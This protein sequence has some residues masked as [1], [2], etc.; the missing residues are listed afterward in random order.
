MSPSLVALRRRVSHLFDDTAPQTGPVRWFNTGLA[1]LIIVNVAA[2]ILESVAELRHAYE[3]IFWWIEQVATVVF[4]IEYLLRLWTAVDIAEGRYRD[5][6]AGRWRYSISFF[7][8]VDLVSILPAVLGMLGAAD[9]R[10]LRLLRLVRM[11]KLTRHSTVFTLLW[12]VV[13]EEA[14]SIGAILFIL[15][16]TLTMSGA[17][18]YMIEGDAQPELFSS[19]P[20]AMWWAIETL[21]TVGYGDVVPV[22]VAG[23]LLGGVVSVIGIGTLALFSGVITVSFMDQLR[24]RRERYRKL[25]E[26]R[27][28]AGPI[29]EAQLREL[30]R[31]GDRLALP[32]GEAE[33]AIEE[34]VSDMLESCPHCGHAL[35]P[36]R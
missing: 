23:R 33:E 3:P 18:M 9:F 10:V 4:S 31:F 1:A 14:R 19:I 30:E 34:A 25:V 27:L 12:A 21:T 29:S 35:P 26:L 6:V 11:L 13:R 28:A 8:L 2:V 17:L 24:L 32:E 36:R 5:P 15:F 16:L 22:T 7:A 20:V